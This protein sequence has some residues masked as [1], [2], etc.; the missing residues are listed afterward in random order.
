MASLTIP[1]FYYSGFTQ[2]L[3]LDEA[4]RN[5]LIESLAHVK[6]TLRIKDVVT[7]VAIGVPQISDGELDDIIKVIISL[8]NLRDRREI[9]V[10]KLVS[11]LTDAVV[12][13]TSIFKPDGWNREDFSIFLGKILTVNSALHIVAKAAGVLTDHKFVYCESRVLTDVRPVFDSDIAASPKAAVIVHTLKIIYHEEDVHKE[14]FV[15]LDTSD[16]RELQEVLKRADTKTHA[17]KKLLDEKDLIYLDVDE[18]E[19]S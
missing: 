10:D 9:P 1:K 5:H 4:T 14:F 3:K 15:A 13:L 7:Q 8:Y 2:L 11:E 16:L 18:Q 19:Q 6:Q 12:Q 17:L